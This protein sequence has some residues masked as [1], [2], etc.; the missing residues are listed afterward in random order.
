MVYSEYEMLEWKIPGELLQSHSRHLRY[1]T[2]PSGWLVGTVQSTQLRELAIS[3]FHSSLL[4]RHLYLLRS[5]PQLAV[6]DVRIDR[7]Q[8]C[9]KVEAAIEH[10][11]HLTSLRISGLSLQD[12]CIERLLNNKSALRKL[13]IITPHSFQFGKCPQPLAN[14]T[15]L[16][17]ETWWERNPGQLSLIRLCPN[18]TTVRLLLKGNHPLEEVSRMLR[19]HCPKLERIECSHR[20]FSVSHHFE[21]AEY[22]NLD[23]LIGQA[24]P[25]LVHFA[26]KARTLTNATCQALLFHAGWIETLDL[27]LYTG[28][29]ESVRNIG[30]ILG[31]CSSLRTL[32][33][34][35]VISM[36]TMDL[37][38]LGDPW[39]CPDL[40]SID[41]AGLTMFNGKAIPKT[42]NMHSDQLKRIKDIVVITNNKLSVWPQKMPLYHNMRDKAF[43][44]AFANQ[45]WVHRPRFFEHGGAHPAMSMKALEIRDLVFERVSGLLRIHRIEVEL[46]EYLRTDRITLEEYRRRYLE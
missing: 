14:L 43:L 27:H 42:G 5:N 29:E 18:M 1:L 6:L 32:K 44:D 39:G 30:R 35:H 12:L 28:D 40:E 26:C 45:G 36:K 16:E 20:S 37:G 24:T 8:A 4:E 9:R 25:R 21:E 41:L 34:K 13:A 15:C 38:W 31:S 2:F 10:L 17:M 11:S 19:E 7:I 33:V 22:T 3:L 46:F 23:A